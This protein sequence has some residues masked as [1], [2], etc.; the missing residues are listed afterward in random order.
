MADL[1][2]VIKEIILRS[3]TDKLTPWKRVLPQNLTRSQLLKKTFEFYKPRVFI[4]VITRACRL[5]LSSVRLIQFT[6]PPTSV[7]PI[8]I[9]SPHLRL[10][11]PSDLL[12]SGFPTKHC[13]HLSSP[14]FVLAALRISVFLILS[15][16]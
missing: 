3:H 7:R 12:P 9:L 2:E 16:E 13:I 1:W 4:T 8:L 15:S 14:P 5:S 11:L 10:G 6:P